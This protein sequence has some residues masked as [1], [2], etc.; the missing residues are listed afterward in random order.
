[1]DYKLL[2][3]ILFSFFIGVGVG[4][5]FAFNTALHVGNQ[6]AG[7]FL[8]ISLNE[9]GIEFLKTHSYKLKEYIK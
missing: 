9:N 3:F 6:L 8:N 4:A 2:F 7:T 5:Y 1:M